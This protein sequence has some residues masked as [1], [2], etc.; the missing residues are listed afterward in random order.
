VT[1][2]QEE[3]SSLLSGGA[4]PSEREQKEGKGER[5]KEVRRPSCIHKKAAFTWGVGTRGSPQGIQGGDR[6]SDRK[7]GLD[8][9][10]HP[11][12]S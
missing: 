5:R 2:Q 6:E 1:F 9:D 7:E 12:P 3:E 11:K 8:Y 4:A 10:R